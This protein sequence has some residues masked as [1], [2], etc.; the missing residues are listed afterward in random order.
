V[1]GVL[2]FAVIAVILYYDDSCAHSDI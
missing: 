2:L 1:I